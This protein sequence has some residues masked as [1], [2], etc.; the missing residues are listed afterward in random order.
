VCTP[1][2][3]GSFRSEGGPPPTSPA[4][5][6]GVCAAGYYCPPGSTVGTQEP[7]PAGAYSLPGAAACTPCPAGRY[8]SSPAQASAACTGPCAPGHVCGPGSTVATATP[9][10]AS[11]FS[12]AGAVECSDCP[13]GTYSAVPGSSSC[14]MA[15][16]LSPQGFYQCPGFVPGA[17]RSFLRQLFNATQGPGWRQQ[18]GWLVG[19]PCALAWPMVTCGPG[20]VITYVCGVGWGGVGWG[21]V[22]WGGVGSGGVGWAMVGES[23]VLGCVCRWV[24]MGSQDSVWV[25][26]GLVWGRSPSRLPLPH[27]NP[28]PS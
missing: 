12:G 13:E 4:A 19:D 17:Q 8:G 18:Q 11:T 23:C 7:C 6:T 9:C 27:L 25:D 20:P 5:C 2:P 3:A 28:L 1:C 21:G 16:T 15:C 22:G 24:W 14:P 26:L 10:P